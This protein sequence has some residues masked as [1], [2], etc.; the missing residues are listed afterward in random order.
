[1]P[2]LELMVVPLNNDL[3]VD[4]DYLVEVGENQYNFEKAFRENF[5]TDKYQALFNLGFASKNQKM[6]YSLKYLYHICKSFLH[7]LILIPELD[8][9]RERV[10]VELTNE[11][12]E[13]FLRMAPGLPNSNYLNEK[14]IK[15]IWGFINEGYQ[16]TVRSLGSSSI[17][18]FLY[19]KNKTLINV[20][21][22]CFHLVENKIDPTLFAFLATFQTYDVD[23]AR[24]KNSSLKK[25]LEQSQT[26]QEQLMRVLGPI[27]S[28]GKDSKFI[29]ELL[30][31]GEVFYPLTLTKEEA[32]TFLSEIALYEKANII[33][34]VPNWWKKAYKTSIKIQ[35][36]NNKSYL[37]FA[38]VADFQVDICLG[39]LE[40]GP[41]DLAE[42]LKQENGLIRYKGEWIHID[43]EKLQE[44]KEAYEKVNQQLRI[45][46]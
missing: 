2:K 5:K 41:K 21:K 33:C 19:K 9:L 20:G 28:A 44:L 46:V 43:Q 39:N 16:L 18:K 32:F 17:Q 35:F 23:S 38:E 24:I 37:S 25:V 8:D 6:S 26:D 4:Y 22:V 42:I 27:T 40:I 3:T 36:G 1:M 45:S 13:Q 15:T 29:N 7:Q 10:V 31:S 11:L 30:E 34:K 14:W 12:A